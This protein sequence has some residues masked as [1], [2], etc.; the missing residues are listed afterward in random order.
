MHNRNA[1]ASV[2]ERNGINIHYPFGRLLDQCHPIPKSS[3]THSERK[4]LHDV[5]IFLDTI[6]ESFI[7]LQLGVFRSYYTFLRFLY[8]MY[9]STFLP[10]VNLFNVSCNRGNAGSKYTQ[11]A[12]RIISGDA[13]CSGTGAALK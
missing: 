2:S 10:S 4:Y 7:G 1:N 6:E 11:S 8:A 12:A 3:D 5:E 9:T 13:R